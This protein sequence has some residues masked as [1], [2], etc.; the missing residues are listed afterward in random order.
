MVEGVV[1]RDGVRTDERASIDGVPALAKQ[2]GVF[3]WID[4]EDPT[5]ATLGALAGEF[6]LHPLVVEDARHR[7]QRPKVELFSD[8]VFVVLRAAAVDDGDRSVM[9]DLSETEIHVFAG[10]GFLVTLRFSPCFDMEQTVRRWEGQPELLAQGAGFPLYVL[11]DEVVDGYLSAVERFE[12]MV[13]DLEDDI[14]AKEDGQGESPQ[15][16]E[17][18]F[19]LKR[20]TVRL[21]RFVSPLR[22][23]IEFVI[24]RQELAGD[25]LAPYYRDVVD[26]VIRADELL[27]NVRDLLT[28]LQ[29]LR[30]AQAANR[31][32]EVMKSLTAWA[33]ILLV[34]TL[35]AGIWG[36]NFRHMPELEWRFGYAFAVGTILASAL[37]LY[38]WFKWKK[39]WL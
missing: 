9:A 27:D 26:H 37:G 13:D 36:M 33:T 20:E 24:G 34:P 7:R 19:H 31:V 30:V 6:R 3:V 25:E 10:D 28:S 22:E 14:F 12:E 32:N 35:F 5:E 8:Y 4:V 11:F 18:L 1:F 2:P 21:R 15:V 17:R 29:E 23:G 16:R 39:R 38:A